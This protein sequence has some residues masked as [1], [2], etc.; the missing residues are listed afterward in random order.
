MVNDVKV[1]IKKA[2]GS[3]VLSLNEIN[4][5]IVEIAQLVNYRQ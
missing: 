5:L 1:V 2:L 3:H 4:T